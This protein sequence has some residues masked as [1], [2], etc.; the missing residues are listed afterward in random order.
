MYNMSYCHW[1]VKF[2]NYCKPWTEARFE[3]KVTS[4][5]IAAEYSMQARLSLHLHMMIKI[6]DKIA[7]HSIGE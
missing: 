3:H 1:K 4:H 2:S 6:V 5:I 7:E